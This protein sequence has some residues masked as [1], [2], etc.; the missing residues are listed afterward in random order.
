MTE[1][2]ENHFL[3]TLEPDEF[4]RIRGVLRRVTV[5]VDQI[6]IDQGGPVDDVYFPIDAQFAN[7]T[8]FA[9]GQAIETAVIG[10]EGIT[11]LAAFMAN[12]NCAWE[13]G[14]R[15]GGEAYIG[16]A[17]ALRALAAECPRLMERLMALTDFYQAQAAQT[18]ACNALHSVAERIARWMLTARDLSPKDILMFRQEELARMIGARRTT[19]SDVASQLKQ[20]KLIAYG[21]GSIRI[22]DRAG[23]E[24]ASCECYGVLKTR[25]TDVLQRSSGG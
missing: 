5:A 4:N 20:R 14:C 1:P 12:R 7:L 6:V 23:L 25:L 21:R 2:F 18:A 22:V 11:G 3:T 15:A 24:A 8:R 10:N 13:V 16:S 19:V 9:D 17:A